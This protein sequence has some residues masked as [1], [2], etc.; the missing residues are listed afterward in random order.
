MLSWV[1]KHKKIKKFVIKDNEISGFR[2]SLEAF[3]MLL[4]G[5]NLGAQ[6]TEIKFMPECSFH[7]GQSLLS[8]RGKTG[9]VI[10]YRARKKSNRA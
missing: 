4:R 6:V 10:T 1:D 7:Q 8:D 5:A 9:Y 2:F 3:F